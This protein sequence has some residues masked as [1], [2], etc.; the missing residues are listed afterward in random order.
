MLT[1]AAE[2]GMCPYNIDMVEV[3][4]GL[5]AVRA[6][7]AAPAVLGVVPTVTKNLKWCTYQGASSG[8]QGHIF[9]FGFPKHA[10]GGRVWV[11]NSRRFS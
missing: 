3:L 7:P 11:V 9:G 4:R 6:M 5:H 10:V 8:S 1:A 2:S